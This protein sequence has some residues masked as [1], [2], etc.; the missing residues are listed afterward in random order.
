MT[1]AEVLLEERSDIE[2]WSDVLARWDSERD[3][4]GSPWLWPGLGRYAR[5]WITLAP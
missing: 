4:G 2:D 3:F 5:R 1:A